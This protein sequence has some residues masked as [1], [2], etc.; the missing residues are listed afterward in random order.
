MFGFDTIRHIAL[1]PCRCTGQKRKGWWVSGCVTEF[2]LYSQLPKKLSPEATVSLSNSRPDLEVLFTCGHGALA[3]MDAPGL[4]S[5]FLYS[6]VSFEEVALNCSWNIPC[7][8]T[9]EMTF[10]YLYYFLSF[11]LNNVHNCQNRMALD[12]YQKA[13][14]WSPWISG[15]ETHVWKNH[16]K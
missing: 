9:E 10:Q 4:L 8:F 13:Y 6:Q 11:S 12:L 2:D 14:S 15:L 7:V 5:T 3:W 1:G 16:Q